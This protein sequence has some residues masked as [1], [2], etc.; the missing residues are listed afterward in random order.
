MKLRIPDDQLEIG[1]VAVHGEEV[2]PSEDLVSVH[3]GRA[4]EV[5]SEASPTT[6]EPPRAKATTEDP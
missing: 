6:L 4:S 2:Y 3:A 1:D 5:F